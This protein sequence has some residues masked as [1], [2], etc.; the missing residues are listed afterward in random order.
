M[1]KRHVLREFSQLPAGRG[2]VT[3]VRNKASC[4]AYTADVEQIYYMR[5][6]LEV[7]TTRISLL[8]VNHNVAENVKL[9]QEMD[10]EATS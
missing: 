2:H 6:F 4:S 9:I 3:R 7:V 1:A 10:Y 5:E 8:P